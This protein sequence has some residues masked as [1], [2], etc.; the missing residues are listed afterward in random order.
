MCKP[1]LRKI[2]NLKSL[3]SSSK[4][5]SIE[6]AASWCRF[7]SSAWIQGTLGQQ[8]FQFVVSLAKTTNLRS[9]PPC[10]ALLHFRSSLSLVYAAG[11]SAK[12]IRF[13]LGIYFFVYFLLVIELKVIICFIVSLKLKILVIINYLVLIKIILNPEGSWE[14]KR[15][16]TGSHA[17]TL[18]LLLPGAIPAPIP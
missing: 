5:R 10:I 2:S 16:K 7:A 1:T 17:Q 6:A 15:H 4:L 18:V 3:S 8:D 11:N 14:C 9:C 12:H 13:L